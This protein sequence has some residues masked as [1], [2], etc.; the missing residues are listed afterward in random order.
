MA[1]DPGLRRYSHPQTIV[2]CGSFFLDQNT[3]SRARST[4]DPK[5]VCLGAR[6]LVLVRATGHSPRPAARDHPGADIFVPD[7]TGAGNRV[8]TFAKT[9]RDLA[10]DGA[11]AQKIPQFGARTRSARPCQRTGIALG[12]QFE[13][14]HPRQF[15]D[16]LADGDALDISLMDVVI[17]IIDQP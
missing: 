9:V 7:G 16:R 5:A 13:R 4:P 3:A 15:D 6:L 14:L 8:P 17:A 11:P 2:V 12:G 10:F 1:G